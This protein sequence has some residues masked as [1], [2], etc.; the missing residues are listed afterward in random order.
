MCVSW[1]NGI[2]PE[3]RGE[4][5]NEKESSVR[6]ILSAMRLECL[7]ANDNENVLPKQRVSVWLV[8]HFDFDYSDSDHPMAGH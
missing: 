7:I 1:W 3:K 6:I 8:G 5:T 2:E 4:R